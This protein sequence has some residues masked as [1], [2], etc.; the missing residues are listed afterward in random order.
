MIS[1]LMAKRSRL[2]SRLPVLALSLHLLAGCAASDPSER[3]EG[4]Y[5]EAPQ[6]SQE[7]I[8]FRRHDA[9]HA[10][11][12]GRPGLPDINNVLGPRAPTFPA[13]MPTGQTGDPRSVA[14][15]FATNRQ[16][17]EGYPFDTF[18]R[19]RSRSVTYGAVMVRVP[20]EHRIGSIELPRE[21]ITLFSITIWPGQAPNPSRHFT[22]QS[23]RIIEKNNWHNFV[24]A[25]A[26]A[27][28]ILVFVHGFNNTFEDSIRRAAQLKWDLQHPGPVVSFSWPAGGGVA[29]YLYDQN[30]ARIAVQHFRELIAS[31][32][33]TS[34]NRPIHILAHSMGNLVVA[35]ALAEIAGGGT[36]TS[37]G[38]YILAAPDI[39]NEELANLAAR[40]RRVARGMTIYASA[41]DR[42]LDLSRNIARAPRAG[43]VVNGRPI[44]LP[45]ADVI[46]ATEAG[47]DLLSL[48]HSSYAASRT[49]LNDIRL[50]LK[51]SPVR[52]RPNERL[53]EI[54]PV[55]E[56][57][58]T[59]P[60]FWRIAP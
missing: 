53:A 26:N 16:L 1:I 47:D 21:P 11:P 15:Y 3:V 23:A 34:G 2:L 52:L 24:R 14:V 8:V 41:A 20:E 25:A 30:S 32:T 36:R 5:V 4:G 7:T 49:L 58:S 46:D 43:D 57:T 28:D 29:N 33:E 38:E 45:E 37:V 19:E 17:L 60:L 22:V 56:S 48:G 6:V 40:V 42:A 35:P 50:L 44:S 39:D 55:P 27:G 31:L 10:I 54:R 12:D 9:R 51:P 59:P 13:S 18:T